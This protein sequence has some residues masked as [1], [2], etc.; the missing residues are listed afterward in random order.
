MMVY[1]AAAKYVASTNYCTE[2]EV[3]KRSN[4]GKASLSWTREREEVD[5]HAKNL[6]S[7]CAARTTRLVASGSV[8]AITFVKFY[9][10]W[11]RVHESA[12]FSV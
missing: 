7:K 5:G 8:V 6:L 3:S 10:I 4:G 9:I 2:I 1:G 11:C 12:C